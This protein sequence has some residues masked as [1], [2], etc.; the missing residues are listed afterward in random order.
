LEYSDCHH[1]ATADLE[2]DM[3]DDD[4]VP[5]SSGVGRG[6]GRGG[7]PVLPAGATSKMST[8]LRD[9]ISTGKI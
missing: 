1:L 2:S 8:K 7:V 9:D 4:Q 3:G 6:R 5:I